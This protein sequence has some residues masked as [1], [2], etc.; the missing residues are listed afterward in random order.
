MS[1]LGEPVGAT[2]L[3]FFLL[4]EQLVSSQIAGGFLV[5]LGVFFFL[6]QQQKPIPFKKTVK[7]GTYN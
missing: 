6:I 5:L 1:I 3:A 2:T 4:G 7:D